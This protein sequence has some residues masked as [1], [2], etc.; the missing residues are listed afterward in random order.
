[1]GVKLEAHLWRLNADFPISKH[2]ATEV[3][4]QGR[5]CH[6]NNLICVYIAAKLYTKIFHLG[7]QMFLGTLIHCHC[8]G[9]YANHKLFRLCMVQWVVTLHTT[10]EQYSMFPYE[11]DLEP[12]L[13]FV[14]IYMLFWC[15]L[16]YTT[17][18]RKVKNLFV[19]ANVS[20]EVMI[21]SIN[22]WNQSR[23]IMNHQSPLSM[24]HKK[25]T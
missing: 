23:I 17:W 9:E 10:H 13:V 7:S 6:Q 24:N 3:C 14:L 16:S 1:M 5:H 2:G 15:L 25:A 20:E 4:L 22:F 19:P 12:C 21:N 8:G 18:I 11:V